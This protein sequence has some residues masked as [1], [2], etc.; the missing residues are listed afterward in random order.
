MATTGAYSI[1]TKSPTASSRS[2]WWAAGAKKLTFRHRLLPY[3]MGMLQA[4]RTLSSIRSHAKS[5]TAS[6]PPP[7]RRA[8]R[9]PFLESALST[10]FD[11]A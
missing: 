4:R 2:G 8:I 10:R 11:I 9:C 6:Q 1:N 3:D 7:Q 5:G